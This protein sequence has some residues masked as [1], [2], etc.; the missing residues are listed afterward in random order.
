MYYLKMIHRINSRSNQRLKSLLAERDQ[1]FFFEGEK[2][3][4]D[5]LEKKISIAK[6]IINQEKESRFKNQLKKVEEIWYVNNSVMKKVS[7]LKDISDFIAVVKYKPK[8]IDFGK[9]VFGI[10]LDNV[11]DPGNAGT[12]FRCA[13]AFGIDS[14][15]FSGDCVHLNNAKLLRTAQTS[16]FDVDFQHFSHLKFIF[17]M[18][19]KKNINVYL[20]SADIHNNNTEIQK[21][22]FPCI[23]IF[24]NEGIGLSKE[25]FSRFSTIRIPQKRTVES[26]NVGVSGCIVMYELN[27]L[28]SH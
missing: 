12:L 6:L 1:Y 15:I 23:V 24:G 17:Q 16:I 26:L 7:L 9:L 19:Q 22:D 8:Q 18:C 20:T 2:L 14:L 5:I 21:I 4:K 3:V 11:Q 13:A 27:K 25:L 28:L 10:V